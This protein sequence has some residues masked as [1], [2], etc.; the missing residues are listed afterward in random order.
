[1]EINIFF[2]KIQELIPDAMWLY[3]TSDS[4]LSSIYPFV[5]YKIF[6]KDEFREASSFS[7]VNPL[8]NPE[9]KSVWTLVYLDLL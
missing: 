7:N 4:G 9:R 5:S 3:F 6:Y 1:L 2:R 8:N